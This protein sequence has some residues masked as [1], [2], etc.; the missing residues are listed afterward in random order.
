MLIIGKL[1]SRAPVEHGT[2]KKSYPEAVV[3]NSDENS[4]HVKNARTDAVTSKSGT[5][6][7]FNYFSD[8]LFR[9]H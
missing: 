6:L 9:F 7:Y 3:Q 4:N 2:E 1:D 5:M 8:C